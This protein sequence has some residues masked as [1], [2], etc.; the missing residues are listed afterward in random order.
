MT[1]L[2]LTCLSAVQM[3][4]ENGI[5]IGIVDPGCTDRQYI[6]SNGMC[7]DVV[8]VCAVFEKIGGLCTACITGYALK[9]GLCE[10]ILCP[11]GQFAG[12]F[13]NCKNVS[14]LCRTW[15]SAGR[16]LTCAPAHTVNL[17]GE[18]LQNLMTNPC[19]IGFFLLNNRCTDNRALCSVANSLGYC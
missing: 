4:D 12:E 19:E 15:D 8:A 9:N 14:P 1:G 5:C 16:C 7:I 17:D 10:E 6:D 2:C 11:L 3:V 18:C 13:G